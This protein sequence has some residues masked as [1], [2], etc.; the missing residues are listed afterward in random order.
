MMTLKDWVE[1]VGFLIAMF[2]S[3]VGVYFSIKNRKQA[4]QSVQAKTNLDEAQQASIVKQLADSTEEMYLKRIAS[5]KDDIRLQREQ[6]DDA[7]REA[8]EAKEENELLEDFFFN[9]HQPWDR[10]LLA[11]ARTHGWTVDDP[12]SWLLFLERKRKLDE[13]G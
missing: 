3:I 4:V 6:L 11:E 5:F 8:K 13:N 1:L 7:R 2:V 9:H 10:K 12:P